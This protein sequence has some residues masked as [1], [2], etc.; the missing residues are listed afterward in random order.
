MRN[1]LETRLG[2]FVALAVLAS[3]F[4]LEMVGGFERFVGGH[5]YY[6]LFNN[7]QELKIGDRVKMAGVEVGR[8]EDIQ[9]TNSQVMVKLKVNRK[10]EVTTS[11]TASIKFT[12]LLGQNFVSLDFGLT[13]GMPADDGTFLMT[14]EQPDL[15]LI[16]GK[17]DNVASSVEKL[18]SSFTGEKIDNL[19]GPLI[20]VLQD[21]REPIH[22]TMTN[23][24]FITTQI[25]QSEGSVGRF[26]ND[27]GT[28]YNSALSTVSNLQST[29]DDIKL[30]LADARKVVDRVNDG[31]G[32]IGKLVRD[33]ALYNETTNSM[34][35]LRQ[36]LEKINQGKGSVGKL[37]NDQEIFQK[38]QADTPEARQGHRGS[39]RPRPV[40]HTLHS[41][42]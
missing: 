20:N 16:M 24:Q 4:I 38:R 28:F 33:E 35:N 12:G 22:T 37:V 17:L 13:N 40:K 36:I 8:V 5:K 7:A 11:T 34:S 27:E 23:L 31:Q 15:N 3:V 26:I 1:S 39:R 32:T 41:R 21:N 18:T 19:L 9:L 10:A 25:A 2:I 6:A 30:T 14:T 29:T 42:K